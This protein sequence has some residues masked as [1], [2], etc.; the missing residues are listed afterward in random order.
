[1]IGLALILTGLMISTHPH[2]FSV[3]LPTVYTESY[4]SE[5]MCPRDGTS[6]LCYSPGVEVPEVGVPGVG[7]LRGRVLR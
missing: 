1:M 6:P 3:F 5:R 7:V 2:E 4:H